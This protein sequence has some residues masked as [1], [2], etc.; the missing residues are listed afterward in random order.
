VCERERESEKMGER[1]IE[2]ESEMGYYS[3][4]QGFRS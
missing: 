3:E 2:S 1:I 4:F